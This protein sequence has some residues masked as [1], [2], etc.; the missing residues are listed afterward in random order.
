MG[1]T[2][3]PVPLKSDGVVIASLKLP[4]VFELGPSKPN[5]LP[6]RGVAV[7]RYAVP[8]QTH[9]RID[10]YDINGRRMRTVVDAM[11]APGWYDVAIAPDGLRGGVY[12]FQMRAGSFTA[13]R[14]MVV[15]R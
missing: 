12:F 3:T 7:V 4:S 1:S 13:A 6:G 11:K 5:P 15:T 14:R 9:V 2:A 10:L 8:K